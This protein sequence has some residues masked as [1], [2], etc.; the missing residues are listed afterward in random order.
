VAVA[1]PENR[2]RFAQ[3]TSSSARQDVLSIAAFVMV[4]MVLFRA[5]PAS[6]ATWLGGL[7]QFFFA[8][9]AVEYDCI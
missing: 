9:F 8:A 6:G 7:G 1:E 4:V 2:T 5:M 3:S